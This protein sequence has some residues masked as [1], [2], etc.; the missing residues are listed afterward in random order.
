MIKRAVF[1]GLLLGVGNLN[2]AYAA[3]F[4]LIEQS[5]SG[6]GNAYA[7]MAARGDDASTQFFNPANLS[8]LPAGRQMVLGLSLVKPSA[9]LDDA[10]A[11][12]QGTPIPGNGGGDAGVLAMV[13]NF[14]YADDLGNKLKFGL[15]VTVP[16]G[17]S[18]EYNK[19]WV[20]RYH[21]LD[22]ELMTLN[23]NPAISWQATETWRWVAVSICNTSRP[24]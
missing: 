7:G 15:G 24:D 16:Y 10:R 4:A 13:P 5:A 20:G 18:S 3:G 2:S 14:Y 12:Q 1:I 8:L 19:G 21:A 17:L 6:F 23:I 22:S 11:S 9:K